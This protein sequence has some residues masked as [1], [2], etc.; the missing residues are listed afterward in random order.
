MTPN[1]RLT[2]FMTGKSM[3]RALAIPVVCSMSGRAAGMTH[4]EKR[5]TALNEALAQVACYE[6]FG[7][8]LTFIEYGL[9]G[10]GIALGGKTSDPED[11]VPAT[12]EYALDDLGNV[13]H[14]DM[15]RLELK[16]DLKFQKHIEAA[17]IL[18]DKIGR[19]APTGVLISGP[20]TAASSVYS[21]DK[22]LRATRRNPEKL[23]KLIRFCGEA[24]K[25]IYREFIQAGC[26]ILF[27]DPI[28][29]G[30]ILARKQYLDFVLPYTI[31]LMKFIHDNKGMACY[32]ICGDT[33][34]IV[35]DMGTS[36]C[37]MISIDNGV[38]LAYAKKQIGGK[39][40]L[41]GNVDPVEVLYLGTTEDVDRAVKKCFQKAYDSPCGYILA[42][43]CDI[44]G[45]L[46]LE[47]LD[48]FMSSARKY[49]KMPLNP[50]NF[51]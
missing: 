26:M 11:A 17:K 28:A 27:C 48:Q 46:P 1:E 5:S 20:F 3:D 2:A 13:D 34:P 49:G 47:N 39:M 38:D 32:H 36:G 24:L 4:K 41:L 22:L 18:I 9:H 35:A 43:G 16:N 30:T 7:N 10:V 19:E 33:T 21:V 29:S 51:E 50:G 37:D 42:S 25:M 40:P 44:N 6:R 8:D 23:H 12:L 14:L 31:D 15:S 45:N